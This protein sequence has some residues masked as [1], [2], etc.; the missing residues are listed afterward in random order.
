MRRVQ[1]QRLAADL[2]VETGPR[3]VIGDFNVTP[4]SPLFDDLLRDTG[5]ID[6]RRVQ[7]LQ[8]TWP[9]YAL[10]LW[11]AIDHCL[12]DEA[13]PVVDVRHGPDIGSDHY[14][15]EVTVRPTN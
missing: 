13:I 14:P 3:M 15:L 1:L 2:A 6:A 8:V 7:G 9:T 10:P 5:L 11:I 12:V 4:F